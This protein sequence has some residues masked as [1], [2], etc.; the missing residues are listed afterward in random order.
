LIEKKRLYIGIIKLVK[1]KSAQI[2]EFCGINFDRKE[3]TLYRHHKIIQKKSAEISEFC[4]INFDR[5]EATLYRHH[6]ISQKKICGN[7]PVLRDKF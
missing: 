7:Q 2:S 6:K 4:R 3:A 1:K 5:K